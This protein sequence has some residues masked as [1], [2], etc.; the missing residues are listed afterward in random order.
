[1]ISMHP[2]SPGPSTSL[3]LPV[4]ESLIRAGVSGFPSPAEDYAGRTLDLNARFV[5]RPSATF[6]VDSETVDVGEFRHLS[7]CLLLCDQSIKPRAGHVIVQQRGDQTHV[8]RWL[9]HRG[10]DWLTTCSG[11]AATPLADSGTETTVL[12]VVRSVH[13][14]LV[15]SAIPKAGDTLDLNSQF[16]SCPSASFFMRAAG[17]SMLEYK[18]PDPCLLLLDRS[19]SPAP[20]RIVVAIVDGEAIVKCWERRGR[21][22]LLVSGADRYPP[23]PM[24]SVDCSIWGVVRSAHFEL[25]L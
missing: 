4:F 9:R 19:I 13:I 5:K 18:I 21:T 11:R 14:I 6:Y 23:I 22:D 8:G 3:P 10:R 2:R 25:A 15:E 12:G 1:M 17:D 7:P 24:S 20:G 16:I